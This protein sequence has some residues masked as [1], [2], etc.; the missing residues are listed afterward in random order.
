M[1]Y[2]VTGVAGFIGSTLARALVERGDSVRGIDNFSTGRRENLDGLEAIDLRELDLGE[3]SGALEAACAGVDFIVHQ[4]ALPSV[5]RSI[6]DPQSSHHSNANATLN[7]LLAARKAKERE[8]R[9]RRIVYAGSSSV[10][11]DTP[12]L[13]KREQMAP[14][15]ISPYAVGKLAG[16]LYMQ[17]FYR[18]Y[19]LETV[20]LRYFN[21]FGPRQDPGSQYSGVI[22]RFITA[23]LRGET[24]IIFGDGNQTRDFTY[25]DNV[26]SA[27]LLA[28]RAPAER[29]AGMVFNIATGRQV[30][31][32][33][34]FTSLRKITGY[35]G[36]TKYGA[37]RKGD[38]THSF[39][40]VSQAKDHLEFKVLVDFEEGLR[41]TVDW[42]RHSLDRETAVASKSS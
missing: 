28:C 31:L 11:G 4:A 33:E 2:L 20:T 42:Y 41:R 12:E 23:M 25:V 17:S 29:V 9:L 24:P 40:D 3:Y 32:N 26:V 21:V 6:A 36:E 27:N 14:S 39:A 8:G 38:I 35:N 37:A 7:L 15:P 1:L 13:P 19:G 30:T 18:C 16:E 5:P 34:T 10:Y 22:S